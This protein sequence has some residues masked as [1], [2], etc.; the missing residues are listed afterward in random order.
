MKLAPVQT[1]G[2]AFQRVKLVKFYSTT[3]LSP[4]SD[5]SSH[6]SPSLLQYLVQNCNRLDQEYIRTPLATHFNQLL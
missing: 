5:E 3:V 6:M 1:E 4:S 2:H